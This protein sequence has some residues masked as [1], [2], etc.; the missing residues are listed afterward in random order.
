M[1]WLT[2]DTDAATSTG[3]AS[4]VGARCGGREGPC[5]CMTVGRG[6]LYC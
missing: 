4:I 1:W 5:A 3:S 6:L 2:W